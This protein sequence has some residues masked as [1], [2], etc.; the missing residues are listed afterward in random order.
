M[1]IGIEIDNIISSP[2]SNFTAL[3]EVSDTT[4]LKGARE[5]LEKIKELGHIIIIYTTRDASLGPD[6]EIWLKSNKIPY[7]K[8]FFNKPSFDIAIDKKNYKFDNWES[9]LEKHKYHLRNN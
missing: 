2:I 9:F 4:V 5:S 1:N 7:D 8:I 3:N 6:T